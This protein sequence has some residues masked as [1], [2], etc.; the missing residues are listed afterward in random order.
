MTS[1]H[2]ML[3]CSNQFWFWFYLPMP[4][5]QTTVAIPY[6]WEYPALMLGYGSANINAHSLPL[7]F[8]NHYQL[9]IFVWVT[10]IKG[11]ASAGNLL[12]TV[13]SLLI[14]IWIMFL[15]H[16][17]YIFSSFLS[18]WFTK[19]YKSKQRFVKNLWWPTLW[20]VNHWPGIYIHSHRVAMF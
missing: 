1:E 12:D 11:H 18:I 2:N 4:F 13:D 5:M 14:R 15:N 16:T 6:A 8:N 9:D 3:G 7:P 10:L 17:W 19:D 20:E